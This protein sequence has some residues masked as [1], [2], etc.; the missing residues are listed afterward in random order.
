[1]VITQPD[2]EAVEI[3][4]L[5]DGLFRHYGVDFRDYSYPSIRRRIRNMMIDEKLST[6]SALQERL[7]H[8]P[9]CMERFLLAVSVHVSSMFRDPPFF[10]NFRAAVVPLLRTYP[11]VRI[12]HAGCST[13]E[14]VYSLAILL[15][16]EGLLERS[17][18]YAT[19][20][21]ESVLRKARQGIYPL[22]A[23][24]L[25]TDNYIKSGG[26]RSFSEY[27]T[28]KYEHAIF[29]PALSS[30]VVFAQHNLVGDRSFNEFNV[31]MCRN[32][33]I[34]FNKT[35]QARVHK[36]FYESLC[37][38]GVLALGDRESIKF[39]PYEDC[40]KELVGESKFY[41]RVK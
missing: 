31:I 13:G 9:S 36:L 3:Q 34:Y 19:D 17:K 18:L 1:M 10:A 37:Q 15:S 40:F 39:S 28:A 20:H 33:L 5:L 22:S 12:W 26:K 30:N 6:I 11:Y 29:A 7:L 27:Y 35:L 16:E 24:K 25:Y 8:D 4:L 38:L 21:N 14:E 32:V 2:L 23:M 41:Q